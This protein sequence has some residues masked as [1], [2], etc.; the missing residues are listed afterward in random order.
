MRRLMTLFLLMAGGGAG[1]AD[2]VNAQ[3]LTVAQGT[4]VN[5]F[6]DPSDVV[7]EMNTPGSC[8][9]NYFHI[10]RTA[11]NFHEMTAV[12]LTA[13]SGAKT[14]TFFVQSCTGN[15]NIVSHGFAGNPP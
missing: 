1:L 7:V 2:V 13:F 6:A 10:Q 9:S 3:P 11:T 12:A 5:I 15:R 8:G 4:I 14:M